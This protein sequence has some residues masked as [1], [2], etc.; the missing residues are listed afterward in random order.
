ME[1]I[2]LNMLCK[3]VSFYGSNSNK[4]RKDCLK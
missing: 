1:S 2:E 4:L 3:G